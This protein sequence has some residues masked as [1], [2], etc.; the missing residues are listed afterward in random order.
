[1]AQST[2]KRWLVA[3]LVLVGAALLVVLAVVFGPSLGTLTNR[4]STS[5]S[6]DAA[7]SVAAIK[8][9]TAKADTAR[10]QVEAELAK[11]TSLKR[12]ETALSQK[13]ISDHVAQLYSLRALAAPT[14]L[15][16][17]FQGKDQPAADA[18]GPDPLQPLI[19]YFSINLSSYT[20]AEQAEITKLFSSFG[21]QITIDLGLRPK[22][23]NE[24]TYGT[25]HFLLHY[26]PGYAPYQEAGAALEQAYTGLNKYAFKQPSDDGACL[27]HDND[28]RI[29]VYFTQTPPQWG[30]WATPCKGLLGTFKAG[31]ITA[32]K[33]ES[34]DGLR[35][36]LAHELSHLSQFEYSLVGQSKPFALATWVTESSAE[37]LECALAAKD[38][39]DEDELRA[40]VEKGRAPTYFGYRELSLATPATYGLP[41]GPTYARYFFWRFLFDQDPAAP[42][43]HMQKLW[44]TPAL[45]PDVQKEFGGPVGLRNTLQTLAGFDAYTSSWRRFVSVGYRFGETYS[46]LEPSDEVDVVSNTSFPVSDILPLADSYGG[47][48]MLR[49]FNETP[50]PYDQIKINLRVDSDLHQWVVRGESIRQ[51]GAGKPTAYFENF[52]QDPQNPRSY[53]AMVQTDQA[54]G[55]LIFVQAY[56]ISTGFVSGVRSTVS[57]TVDATKKCKQ[58]P[59]NDAAGGSSAGAGEQCPIGGNTGTLKE[60]HNASCDYSGVCGQVNPPPQQE[61]YSEGSRLACKPLYENYGTQQQ[62]RRDYFE[63]HHL[64]GGL[65]IANTEDC[66]HN[67]WFFA[68]L[69]ANQNG[70]TNVCGNDYDPPCTPPA[71]GD[72]R[73]SGA[74]VHIESQTDPTKFLDVKTNSIGEYQTGDLPP[75]KYLVSISAPNTDPTS[76]SSFL[77]DTTKPYG[78][79]VTFLLKPK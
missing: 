28:S 78:K 6:S 10:K 50:S 19:T 8:Q 46:L 70:Q 33:T 72:P 16:A 44:A 40:K 61:T 48:A 4:S 55:P 68:Y 18:L 58:P 21:I 5:S 25:T 57:Y 66:S 76:Q 34:G 62:I 35:L 17:A 2:K 45:Y 77:I 79:V 65:P 71:T 54:E 13:K 36:L 11:D 64:E 75:D 31:Y 52:V 74:T 7:S 12:I 26:E 53:T 49:V 41:T 47:M 22:V 24:Q 73:L 38:S 1:M 63:Q 29:D 37:F 9:E 32:S 43:R 3:T 23:P 67:F 60:T 14:S 42:Y 30:G 56:A 15:P 59:T 39:L 20:S 27:A 69:D 51:K